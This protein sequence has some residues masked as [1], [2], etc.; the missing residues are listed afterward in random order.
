M[1]LNKTLPTTI[2]D[3]R[4]D[5]AIR[6]LSESRSYSGKGDLIR[7]N[8]RNVS[9][10]S[11]AGQ[12]ILCCLFDTFIEQKT[13]VKN[14][15]IPRRFKTIPIVTNLKKIDEFKRLP[16]PTIQDFETQDLILKGRT[17][18]DILLRESFEEK[19]K[20]VLS[21]D[22]IYDC[23]LVL[24]ELMQNTVDHSTAE[25][26][27][28]YA[29]PWEGEFHA[30]ILD[31]GATVP[32]KMEQK[33]TCADDLEYLELALKE[34]FGTRRQR[35]GGVGLS[36]FFSYLKKHS[37]KLTLISRRAQVRRYFNTRRSQSTSIKYPLMGTWCFARFALENHNEENRHKK[38]VHK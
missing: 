14:L 33:Y 35:P 4:L 25:R 31:M 22:L 16:N 24:N 10:I 21:P 19:F 37:G 20:H 32:A 8:W 6:L 13:M 2:D 15:Y 23:L 11:P 27:Y 3:G 18:L 36:Y 30:G 17:T 1:I 9:E 7:M 5:W 28:L 12:A 26:Y 34:G 38:R 29:G